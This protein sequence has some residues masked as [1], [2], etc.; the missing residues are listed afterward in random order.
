MHLEKKRRGKRKLKGRC[1]SGRRPAIDL[2][3]SRHEP[4]SSASSPQWSILV[5]GVC[6]PSP[7]AGYLPTGAGCLRFTSTNL[8]RTTY[9]CLVRLNSS[10]TATCSP[11]KP[12]TA[13][14]YKRQ[15]Q[16]PNIS[17]FTPGPKAAPPTQPLLSLCCRPGPPGALHAHLSPCSAGRDPT[18]HR[19]GEQTAVAPCR[20]STASSPSF[21]KSAVREPCCSAAPC[22]PGAAAHLFSRLLPQACRRS[23]SP[24]M[25]SE[26]CPQRPSQRARE[27]ALSLV[28]TL[29]RAC[30]ILL[31]TCQACT[32]RR[33]RERCFFAWKGTP[34]AS[35]MRRAY[36]RHAGRLTGTS[37]RS[38]CA[39]PHLRRCACPLAHEGAW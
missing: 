13:N 27:P 3:L 30:L 15:H 36:S 16:N 38:W 11:A 6:S 23:A 37:P 34:A 2:S 17:R 14:L 18:A 33:Q 12:R 20:H 24:G 1:A 26:P 4:A 5:V 10:S 32:V 8:R 7:L 31:L 39:L 29:C 19:P 35:I 21:R 25:L 22:F 28:S 9:R